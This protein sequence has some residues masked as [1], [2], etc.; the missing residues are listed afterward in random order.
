[1]RKKP[2]PYQSDKA[3]SFL[4]CE[5]FAHKKHTA[6]CISLR[7]RRVCRQ[8]CKP[9]FEWARA[10]PESVVAT[11]KYFEPAILKFH[12]EVKSE[13]TN[14]MENIMPKGDFMCKYCG[15]VYQKEKVLERHLNKKHKREV[16]SG[17]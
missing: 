2:P 9:F 5:L 11:A 12:K 3:H 13:Y 17:T 14:I 1:M 7:G 6:A 8:N 10:N 4:S 15:Q 16:R